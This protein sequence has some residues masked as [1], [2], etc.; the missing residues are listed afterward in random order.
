MAFSLLGTNYRQWL[1]P[2]HKLSEYKPF[3]LSFSAM[4]RAVQPEHHWRQLIQELN[5]LHAKNKDSGPRWPLKAWSSPPQ[6]RFQYVLCDMCYMY[7]I[8]RILQNM[9]CRM[10]QFDKVMKNHWLIFEDASQPKDWQTPNVLGASSSCPTP[11]W[12]WTLWS[13]CSVADQKP[14]SRTL[15]RIYPLYTTHFD[16]LFHLLCV[17]INRIKHCQS[18]NISYIYTVAC[19]V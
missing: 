17:E 6:R 4:W 14:Y 9:S 12:T 19:V 2:R 18:C 5:F 11:S 16:E 13:E 8:Y 3:F 1:N 7:F 15:A 10:M